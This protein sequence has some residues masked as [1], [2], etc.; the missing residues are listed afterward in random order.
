MPHIDPALEQ[1]A[2]AN[3]DASF[4]IIVRV[5]GDMDA[6]QAELE[7]IGLMITRR[8]WLIHG[9]ACT[10]AGSAIAAVA[11]HEWVLSIEP[12]QTVHTMHSTDKE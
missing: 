3:P 5:Q 11:A 8:L 4:P 6:R 2:Q 9:F 1:S 12:D 7:A 10:A